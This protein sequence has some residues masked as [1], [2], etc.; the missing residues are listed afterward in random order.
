MLNFFTIEGSQRG[1]VPKRTI[2]YRS[3]NPHESRSQHGD[4]YSSMQVVSHVVRQ[5]AE[6]KVLR[7]R[8]CARFLPCTH[9]CKPEMEDIS[10]AAAVAVASALDCCAFLQHPC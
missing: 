10:K 4:Y 9:I 8:H 3:R 1:G 7:F 5:A 2:N 6:T